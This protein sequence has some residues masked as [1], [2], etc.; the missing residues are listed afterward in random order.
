MTI[1][2]LVAEYEELE[3]RDPYWLDWPTGHRGRRIREELAHRELSG[4]PPGSTSSHPH[5][6][7]RT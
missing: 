3:A 6:R 7:S 2:Q 5:G 4:R 1:A